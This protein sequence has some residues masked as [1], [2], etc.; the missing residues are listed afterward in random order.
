MQNPEARPSDTE[1]AEQ[2]QE[3]TEQPKRPLDQIESEQTAR[4]ERQEERNHQEDAERR[5]ETANAEQ[6]LEREM[7]LETYNDMVQSLRGDAKEVYASVDTQLGEEQKIALARVFNDFNEVYDQEFAAAQEGMTNTPR[8][9]ALA[10]YRAER[11]GS[12]RGCFQRSVDTIMM[13]AQ[14]TAAAGKERQ[15]DSQRFGRAVN[16]KAN[17]TFQ[18]QLNPEMKDVWVIAGDLIEQSALAIKAA[19]PNRIFKPANDPNAGGAN[20]AQ[21]NRAASIYEST[22]LREEITKVKGSGVDV[23]V[24]D[25]QGKEIKDPAVIAKMKKVR[26]SIATNE[27]VNADVIQKAMEIGTFKVTENGTEQVYEG[28]LWHLEEGVEKLGIAVSKRM[29]QSK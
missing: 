8:A 10:K 11:A 21:L 1:N 28:P 5:E 7:M 6:T 20:S 18:G 4:K 3:Q 13:D 9:E 12:I 26:I 22:N 25:E 19:D 16:E 24:I 23:K 27:N 17:E 15:T 14:G 2:R 29:S